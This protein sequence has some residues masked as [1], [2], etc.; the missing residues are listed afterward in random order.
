MNDT[1]LLLLAGS[2]LPNNVAIWCFKWL[3]NKIKK[4][5]KHKMKLISPRKYYIKF[6]SD[7]TTQYQYHRKMVVFWLGNFIPMNVIVGIDIWATLSGHTAIA[8]LMT[9]ILLAINTN[10]SL[11]ANFDTETG[12]AHAA[13]A[14]IRADEIKNGQTLQPA[15]AEEPVISNPAPD[16]T[17]IHVFNEEPAVS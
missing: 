9:A 16:P 17:R 8:L 10:Y 5:Q 15:V 7:P 6:E 1:I 2:F 14:S 4:E 12:D 11:Y 3:R 13:Y